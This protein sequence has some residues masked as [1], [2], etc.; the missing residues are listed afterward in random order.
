MNSSPNTVR[1][2][3]SMLALT[4]LAALLWGRPTELR[5]D[6]TDD[7]KPAAKPAAKADA[8]SDEKP[9][10]D[11]KLDKIRFA[12]FELDGS[13]PENGGKAALFGESQSDLRAVVDRLE[14]AAKDKNIA[15]AVI[16]IRN[17]NISYGKIEELRGAIARFRSSGKKIYAQLESAMPPDYMVACA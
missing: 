11:A 13:L 1:R 3:I 4:L 5:A 8:S 14:K 16:D 12:L 7:K 15:G 6:D 9:A 10:A 17:P 2:P